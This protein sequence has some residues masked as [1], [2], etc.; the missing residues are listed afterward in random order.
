M[1]L[2]ELGLTDTAVED[3]TCKLEINMSSWIYCRLELPLMFQV[4]C[5][6]EH[7][8]D[9]VIICQCDLASDHSAC[10]VPRLHCLSAHAP[11]QRSCS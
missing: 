11:T 9:V 6:N 10:S 8:L 4:Q 3:E 5:S 7:A 1:L 2:T